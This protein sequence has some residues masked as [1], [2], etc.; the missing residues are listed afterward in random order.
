MEFPIKF[1]CGSCNEEHEANFVAS[2]TLDDQG[3]W[4]FDL[5]G[6]KGWV[7]VGEGKQRQ[8]LN[9]LFDQRVEAVCSKHAKSIKLDKNGQRVF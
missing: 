8:A 2:F 3:N 5:G 4:Y 6:K 9:K 1:N 7:V